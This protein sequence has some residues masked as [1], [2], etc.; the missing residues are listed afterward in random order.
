VSEGCDREREW[1]IG[2]HPHELGMRKMLGWVG[3][4]E[5]VASVGLC[6]AACSGC[7]Y[8]YLCLRQ[9]SIL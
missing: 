5:G 1:M 9:Y 4:S 8:V 2:W 7:L 3:L 6:C